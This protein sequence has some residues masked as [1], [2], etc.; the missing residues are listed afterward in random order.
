MH[1]LTKHSEVHRAQ[2]F[3]AS[4][5]GTVERGSAPFEHGHVNS[6]TELVRAG[7]LS[8]VVTYGECSLVPQILQC[9]A[10]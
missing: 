9:I 7:G 2:C 6:F 4:C 1:L 5:V 8:S 10:V 3:E